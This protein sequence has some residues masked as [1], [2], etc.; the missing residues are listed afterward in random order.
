MGNGHITGNLSKFLGPG[1]RVAFD[2]S[3]TPIQVEKRFSW[4]DLAGGHFW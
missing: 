4:A 2:G 1:G 3:G